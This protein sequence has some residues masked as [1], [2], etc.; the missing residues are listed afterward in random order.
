VFVAVLP[1][2]PLAVSRRGSAALSNLRINQKRRVYGPNLMRRCLA[3][4]ERTDRHFLLGGT[5][6]ERQKLEEL[7][8]LL[9][10]AV[11]IVD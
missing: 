11:Q 7:F 8:R 9:Y 1:S 3:A 4:A 6:E 5:A 10:P 2:R